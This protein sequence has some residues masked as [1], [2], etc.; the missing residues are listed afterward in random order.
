MPTKDENK[1]FWGEDYDWSDGGESWT[2]SEEWRAKVLEI[3][4]HKYVKPNQA[5]LEIGPGA[6]RFTVELLKATPTRLAL[7]DLNQKC[8]DLCQQRFGDHAVIEYHLNDGA[9]LPMLEDTSIDFVWSFDVFVHIEAPEVLSYFK[10]F[11]R[12]LRPGCF[13]IVHYASID[14]A[15]DDD[16]R[17]GWR[18]DFTSGQMM[19]VLEQCGLK[20]EEDL[21]D[22]QL[23]HGNSS[24]VIFSKPA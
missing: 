20:L 7:V 22:E 1:Q 10:E 24:I 9:S 3:T 15:I 6:G 19:G 16:T 18:A 2:P 8:L 13:G 14:R 23:S 5:I 12:V 17:S 11:A 21:Y 4:I